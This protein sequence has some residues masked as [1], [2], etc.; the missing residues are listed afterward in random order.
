MT[1]QAVTTYAG[2]KP[3]KKFA[4]SYSKL[5][6]FEVCP[7]R[8]YHIDLKKDWKE[9]EGESLKFGNELHKAMALRISK[10]VALPMPYAEYEGWCERVVG[11]GTAE[12]MVEQQLA[13]NSDYEPVEWFSKV[14]WFRA[15]A[16]VIKISGPVAAVLDWK[17]G[18]VLEDSQQLMLTA[19]C[20]FAHRP[21]ILR[22]R[23]EFV[24]L[25]H[26]ATTRVDIGREDL[27]AMWVN[28]HPRIES[29]RLAD[30]KQEYPAKPGYLCKRYCPVK[31]CP[32]HGE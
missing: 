7:K 28:L 1:I 15:V 19:A 30:E 25:A 32:H 31:V 9:E 18:K 22:I 27:P 20:V 3:A 24:W 5:K 29:L 23:S 13:I 11:D 6:N 21:D 4:F 16:D 17:T 2:G 26:D 12:V 10:G 8:H 14:A